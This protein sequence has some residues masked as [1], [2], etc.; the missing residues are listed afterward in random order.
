MI[1][2]RKRV[3]LNEFSVW[4]HINDHH[5][6]CLGRPSRQ[7]ILWAS[8][9]PVLT[10]ITTENDKSL[11]SW[12]A[13]WNISNIMIIIFQSV[14]LLYCIKPVTSVGTSKLAMWWTTLFFFFIKISS[15][16]F[17]FVCPQSAGHVGVC[18]VCSHCR[19]GLELELGYKRMCRENISLTQF[20]VL[21]YQRAFSI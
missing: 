6:S 8:C 16:I 14:T 21:R 1:S 12:L 9:V 7:K 20:S 10:G 13:D 11:V 19:A 4:N 15:Y 5:W 18:C 2:A 3:A 17:C